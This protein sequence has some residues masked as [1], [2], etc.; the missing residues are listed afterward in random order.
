MPITSYLR[1]LGLF[2]IGEGYCEQVPE[3]VADLKDL[4]KDPSIKTILEIGFNA[5]HS[6]ELFLENNPNVSV[7]SFDIGEHKYIS[8]SKYYLDK[9]YPGR[10]TLILGDSRVSIP[11]YSKENPGKTFD[12]IFI[13]GGHEYEVARADLENCAK[14]ADKNSLVLLDDTIFTEE[15][16]AHWTRGPTQTWVEHV[17]SNKIMQ[18]KNNDYCLARGMV[19]GKYII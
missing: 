15:L 7:T 4:T 10:H 12:I 1:S 9:M 3:Q 14:L 8:N 17:K 19:W 13:D 18:I 2:D 6:S 16:H 5:G 11:K